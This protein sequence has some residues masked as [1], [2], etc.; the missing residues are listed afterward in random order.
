MV[1]CYRLWTQGGATRASISALLIVAARLAV[2]QSTYCEGA[3]FVRSSYITSQFLKNIFLSE[4]NDKILLLYARHSLSWKV[5]QG[6]YTHSHRWPQEFSSNHLISVARA[7]FGKDP[8]VYLKSPTMA[9]PATAAISDR[10]M[11]GQIAV[12]V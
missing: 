5:L 8:A 2:A 10:L 4:K 6:S 12:G 3:I 7:A 9:C 1:L 11:P